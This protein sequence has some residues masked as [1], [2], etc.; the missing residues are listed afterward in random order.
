[1]ELLED[2]TSVYSKV[3][4]FS[5][6]ASLSSLIAMA[7]NLIAMA[8]RIATSPNKRHSGHSPSTCSSTTSPATRPL[9]DAR[10]L[11][12][13][14]QMLRTVK[15]GRCGRGPTTFR[16]RP[17][18]PLKSN[19]YSTSICQQTGLIYYPWLIP[20]GWEVPMVGVRG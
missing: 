8:N 9:Q 3:I 7:S 1:M 14:L 19:T 13:A 17:Q 15:I 16:P 11:P 12:H 6:Q 18:S 20:A 10:G 2:R 5:Q 4:N